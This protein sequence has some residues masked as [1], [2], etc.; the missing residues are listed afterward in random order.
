M[1]EL[2]MTRPRLPERPSRTTVSCSSS[3]TLP[4][5]DQAML[6]FAAEKIPVGGPKEEDIWALF[7][8][9]PMPFWHRICYLL[10]R[11]RW[12][13]LLSTATITELQ[14]QAMTQFNPPRRFNPPS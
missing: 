1:S 14:A 2:A 5:V 11:D 8:F 4:D 3:R 12:L 13:Q 10:T 6:A 9:G 7:G